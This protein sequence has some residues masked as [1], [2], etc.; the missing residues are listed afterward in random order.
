MSVGTVVVMQL[1][2]SVR[3]LV[4][5]QLN[6]FLTVHR[7]S[8]QFVIARVCLWLSVS[9]ALLCVCCVGWSTMYECMTE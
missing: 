5:A 1:L 7:Q 6:L 9:F 2:L 3:V 4:L 8:L